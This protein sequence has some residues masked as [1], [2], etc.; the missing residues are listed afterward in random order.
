MS[1]RLDHLIFFKQ[2]VRAISATLS[3]V[4]SYSNRIAKEHLKT[5]SKKKMKHNKIVLLARSK[6]KNINK[7]H[8]I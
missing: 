4:H 7:K 2:R 1:K 8:N 3:L 6:L 5:K